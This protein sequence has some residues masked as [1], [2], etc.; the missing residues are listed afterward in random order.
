MKL[1]ENVFGIVLVVCGFST[2]V[3]DASKIIKYS[4]SFPK[5]PNLQEYAHYSVWVLVMG[6]L[7]IIAGVF[8][9]RNSRKD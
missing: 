9:L 4:E 5:I 8:I 7:L 6:I 2:T 1:F 3:L